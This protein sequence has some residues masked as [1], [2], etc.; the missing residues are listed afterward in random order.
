MMFLDRE[1]LVQQKEQ[2]KLQRAGWRER[3]E[4]AWRASAASSVGG[5]ASGGSEGKPLKLG[6]K[7]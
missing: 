7:T 3:L 6:R 1:I 5:Q 4:V 2:D